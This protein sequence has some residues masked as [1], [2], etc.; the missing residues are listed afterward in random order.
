VSGYSLAHLNIARLRAPMDSPP[1]AGFVAQLESLNALADASPGF[2]WR[3]KDED[4]N[5]PGVRALGEGM[6]INLSVWRDSS[7]LAEFVYRSAHA[8]VMR[9]RR[10]WFTQLD[11][12]YVVLWWVAAGDVPTILEAARRLELLR[13]TGASAEGFTFRSVFPPPAPDHCGLC[14]T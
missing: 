12:P 10:E 1:M 5:D 6:L 7:S 2:I 11:E 8:G 13:A 4:P 3:L 9:R 14:V